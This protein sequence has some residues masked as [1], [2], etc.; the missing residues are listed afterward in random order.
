MVRSRRYVHSVE[1]RGLVARTDQQ[2]LRGSRAVKW[3]FA[4]FFICIFFF[5]FIFVFFFSFFFFCFSW[6]LE[7]SERGKGRNLLFCL[8]RLF[9]HSLY[10][11]L[12]PH[13][14]VC[15][16]SSSS[17]GLP[18]SRLPERLLF[19]L[20]ATSGPHAFSLNSLLLPSFV[21]TPLAKTQWYKC[22]RHSYLWVYNLSR[23]LNVLILDKQEQQKEERKI[24][25]YES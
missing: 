25:S 16:Q 3:S 1:N 17:L 19:Q 9:L 23:G 6:A 7:Q 20:P 10:P 5:S 13:P 15:W 21:Y 24:K 18:T 12:A 4:A 14:P 8:L 11:S 2:E 22:I